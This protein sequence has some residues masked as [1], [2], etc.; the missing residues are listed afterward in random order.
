M[1]LKQIDQVQVSRDCIC[2]DGFAYP[3][4]VNVWKVSYCWYECSVVGGSNCT[5]SGLMIK[6]TVCLGFWMGTFCG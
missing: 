2:C 6:C 4:M 1:W 5:V 3:V